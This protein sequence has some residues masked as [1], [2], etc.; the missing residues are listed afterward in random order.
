MNPQ[1]EELRLLGGLLSMP[2]CDALETLEKLSG[3]HGWLQ[4][5]L[6]ELNR[7]PLEHWQS[8][9]TRLFLNGRNAI[10]CPPFES[11]Y[12]NHCLANE[13]TDQLR[14]LY[15]KAGIEAEGFPADYLGTQLQCAAYLLEQDN[16]RARELFGKLWREHLLRWLPAFIADL[17]Q[18]CALRFY[19]LVAR[20]LG[21][22]I[23]LQHRSP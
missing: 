2:C 4:E 22:F 20:R 17:E 21:R 23:D 1:A 19:L 6:D 16:P 18:A 12:R 11:A 8:E 14:T 15:R 10:P 13:V 9:Y 7:L 5:A 3:Q